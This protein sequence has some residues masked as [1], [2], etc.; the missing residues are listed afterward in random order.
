M[1]ASR[2]DQGAASDGRVEGSESG[3]AGRHAALMDRRSFV[4]VAAAGAAMTALHGCGRER[5]PPTWSSRAARRPDRSQVAIL[6]A[7]SYDGR[8]LEDLVERGARLC[9]LDVTGLRVVLKPNLV[10]F[11]P[12]GVINTHPVLVGAA[13]AAF[14]RMGA[15]QVIVAEGPGHRRDTEYI[16]SATGFAQMLRDAGATFVDLNYDSV[17]LL[18][19]LSDFSE[20]GRLYLPDT[21]L[22]ADLL[23]SMPKMKTHHWTGVTLSMKNLFGIM[24]GCAYGWPKNALHWAGLGGSIVDINSTVELPRFNIVDGIVGMEGNGPIQGEAKASGVLVFGRDPVAV[25]ATATRLMS[26]DPTRITYLGE[27]GRFLGNVHDEAIEL[28]GEPLEAHRENYN[29]LESFESAKVAPSDLA[30]S[31]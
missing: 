5:P 28:I 10:E 25:D 19:A 26:L 23:V 1:G 7:A 31:G 30:G 20:L 3:G 27:A 22:D 21:V 29:V 12:K 4:G 16:L 18:P 14:R 24:P 6:S 13:V 9:G 2:H 15:S 8:A 11:D 17:R